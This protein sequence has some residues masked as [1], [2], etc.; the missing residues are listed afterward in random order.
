MRLV[1]GYWAPLGEAAMGVGVTR[2]VLRGMAQRGEVE[3]MLDERG[4][5]L[6]AAK[7]LQK[8]R[9]AVA[10]QRR[11][12]EIARILISAQHTTP[13]DWQRWYDDE[14]LSQMRA[15]F[16]GVSDEQLLEGS[17][18]RAALLNDQ[19]RRLSEQMQGGR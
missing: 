4:Y 6:V 2:D 7:D 3:A 11:R 14:L 19:I 18:P 1:D 5:M 15:E 13:G 16:P 12:M 10:I 17:K 9:T 8:I